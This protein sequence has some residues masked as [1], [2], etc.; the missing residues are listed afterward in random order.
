M[1]LLHS[2]TTKCKTVQRTVYY[3]GTAFIIEEEISIDSEEVRSV[4]TS[5]DSFDTDNEGVKAGYNA[6]I[7][8][9]K[10]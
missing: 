9:I 2:K 10:I 4:I 7:E 3:A 6:R 8:E 5:D 1:E